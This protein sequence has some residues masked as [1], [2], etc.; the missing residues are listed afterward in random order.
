MQVVQ[1][2]DNQQNLIHA[3]VLRAN[4]DDFFDQPCYSL[5]LSRPFIRLLRGYE[6]FPQQKLDDLEKLDVDDRIPIS[7]SHR[8]LQAALE[9]TQDPDIGLKAAREISPGD[10]GALDYAMTTAATVREAIDIAAAYKR[11]INDTIDFHIQIDGDRAFVQTEN[12]VVLPRAALDFQL[13]V[14]YRNH[15][16]RWPRSASDGYEVC[17]TYGKPD[18]IAEHEITFPNVTLHFSAPFAGF[19]IMERDLDAPLSTAD[20][21]LN[22]MMRKHAE[23]TLANLP[24]A[25]SMT[26][27]VRDLIISDLSNGGPYAKRISQ[28]LNISARTLIRRLENEGTTFKE[29]L[30]DIRRRLALNYVGSRDLDLNNT[31]FLLGFSHATAFHRAFKRW[32]DQTP[33]E[34]RRS[35]RR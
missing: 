13:A 27:K 3:E 14:F 10:T 15:F 26:K 1:L 22:A 6:G 33:L 11:L 28:K 30:D 8:L 23:F 9:L 17:F 16:S 24:K 31:A 7:S 5:R 4:E 18:S 34:Y 25:Q 32:T 35:R 20:L 21:N 29:I 2:N 19:T 12:S